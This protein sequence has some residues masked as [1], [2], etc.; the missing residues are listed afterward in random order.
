M[1]ICVFGC[2]SVVYLQ[3]SVKALRVST[4]SGT[5]MHPYNENLYLR[6]HILLG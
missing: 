4:H 3:C 6:F 2:V 1:S 5:N